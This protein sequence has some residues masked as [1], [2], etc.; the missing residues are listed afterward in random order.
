M[1]GLLQLGLLL[2]VTTKAWAA[3]ESAVTGKFAP[4]DSKTYLIIGQTFQ[5]E[6][7]DYV[8]AF[9]QAPAG[10]SHYGEI[11]TG[12]FNQGDD[13]HQQAFLTYMG[14]NYPEAVVEVALSIKDNPAAGGYGAL[15]TKPNG[16]HQA[17]TDI[18]QGK[19]DAKIDQF[20][21]TFKSFPH[22]RFLV[23]IDYEVS[24]GMHANQSSQPWSK[25]LEQYSARGVNLL[26]SPE[27]AK[28]I[29]VAAYKN[30]FNYIAKRIRQ[31]AAVQNVAFVY[32]PVRGFGDCRNLY[33]GDEF[34]DWIGFSV[35][36]HDVCMDC[37]EANGSIS[38]NGT[39]V[40]DP[41]LKQCLEWASTKKPLMICE[42]GFQT[43]ATGQNTESFKTYLS[44]VF[45]LINQYNIK[46]WVYINSDWQAHHWTL[47][48]GDSRLETNPEIK[49][50]WMHQLR[51]PRFIQY[52]GK[53]FTDGTR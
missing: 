50:Y 18:T 17:L 41:N 46:A 3:N 45:G 21:K 42:S 49:G 38:H 11:Y 33:P 7:Q 37:R 2:L 40:L 5:K 31:T 26:E 14:K 20:A 29:D 34:V 32:H 24:M 6:F 12:N 22:I 25:I 39:G 47:P 10:S 53:T 43:P 23:R 13:G 4:P 15:E 27:L 16:I 1:K 30:A 35:F 9:D 19:W 28:E 51:D 52:P 36:N 8:S 44:R 48:W